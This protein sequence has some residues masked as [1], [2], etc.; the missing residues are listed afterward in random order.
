VDATTIGGV[1]VSPLGLGTSR[2]ASLGAGRSR[3]DAARLLDAAADLGVTFID[4]AD[5]Y[6]S[7]ACE[8]WLGEAMTGRS[9]R[10]VVATKCG[11]AT[12]DLPG[13]FR[14]L[15]QP[16]KKV[17]QRVGPKHYLQCSHVRRSI[18]ASLRRLR[19][20]RI[21]I[22]FLH[23]PPAGIEMRDDLFEVLAEAQVAG[24]IGTYGVSSPEP[25]VISAVATASPCRVAQTA[26]NPLS[27]APLLHML[28][29]TAGEKAPELIANHVLMGSVLLS[30]TAQK[31]ATPAVVD[32]AR[33]LEALSADRGVSKPALLLRHAAAVPHVQVV[34]TGTSD[35][36]H[37]SENV[38]ALAAPA[39][40]EDLLT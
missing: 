9:H 15:N 17:R 1:E 2:M 26:V 16:V 31:G 32:L 13:P 25:G 6:G 38:A 7:T 5:T 14:V 35:P 36:A 24:K 22:Y 4:T 8:R 21:E 18:E 40:P 3:R 28:T 37:L 29:G 11:L 34:L 27:T 23:S 19:R 12:A 20:D 10:F 39:G 30:A 33:K